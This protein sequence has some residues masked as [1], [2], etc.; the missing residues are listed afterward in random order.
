[1]YIFLI[2]SLA[3]PPS[4]RAFCRNSGPGQVYFWTQISS[5]GH[6]QAWLAVCCQCPGQYWYIAGHQGNSVYAQIHSAS[7]KFGC[8]P[9]LRFPVLA[10]LRYCLELSSSLWILGTRLHGN[11]FL[12]L[13]PGCLRKEPCGT[14]RLHWVKGRSKWGEASLV[15]C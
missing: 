5:C 6:H 2:P 12:R 8:G 9:A 14:Q 11:Q 10:D 3:G 7:A 13:S 4:A 1:M 15:H